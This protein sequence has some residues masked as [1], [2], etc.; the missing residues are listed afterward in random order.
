VIRSGSAAR[1][2]VLPAAAL[3]VVAALGLTSCGSNL[4]PGVAARVNGTSISEG[5]VDDV[6]QALCAYLKLAN[7]QGAQQQQQ[8]PRSSIR[9]ATALGNLIYM[10]LMN[11]LA[12]SRHLT[13]LPSDIQAAASQTPIPSGLSKSDAD[14]LRT[15]FY[16]FAK[17]QVQQ[18]TLAANL[19]NPDKTTSEG[20]TPGAVSGSEPVLKDWSEKA[21]VDVNPA[22]G[23]WDGS[24][25][26]PGSGSLSEPVSSAATAAAG[27]KDVSSLPADQVC[28]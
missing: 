15:F 22:Y 28:G 8:Y 14:A 18:S 25:V 4:H 26:Q 5:Q 19:R 7:D 17:A 16:G 24:Q 2:R 3:A 12:E 13:A 21:D 1:R 9:S 10:Q 27:G 23:V 6:T 11:S 20:L